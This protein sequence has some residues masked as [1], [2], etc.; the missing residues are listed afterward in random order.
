MHTNIPSHGYRHDPRRR[1]AI[2]CVALFV[3]PLFLPAAAPARSPA[4]P[5]EAV[6]FRGPSSNG[7]FPGELP[8]RR[9]RAAWTF[10]SDGPINASPIWAEGLVVVGSADGGLYG[11]DASTGRRKWRFATGGAVDGPAAYAEGR[12]FVESRDG[13]LYAVDAK[14]GRE[15]WRLALGPDLPHKWGW[16]YLLSGPVV[17]GSRLYVGSGAGEILAVDRG[18]GR[19]DWRFATSGRVRSSPVVADGVVYAGSFDGYLYALDAR[20]GTL[21]WKFATQGVSID[22][23]AAGF[24]RR[25]VQSSPAVAGDLVVVGCRDGHLY[26]VDRATGKERWNFDHQV[27]WVVGSAAI[28]GD[29]AVVG[30]SDARF[31]QAVELS[32]GKELWRARTDSNALSSP[33]VAGGIAV[34]GDDSGAVLAFEAATGREMWRFRTGDAVHSSPLV[35]DGRVYVGSDDGIL[36]ALERDPA[37]PA[38]PRA[39]RAVYFDPRV[40]YRS[41]EGDRELRD[42]LADASYRWVTRRD[43]AQFLE[44]RIADKE[45][46]VV[47]FATD[48]VPAALIEAKDGGAPLVRRYL[49]AGG[50]IVW[51]SPVPFLYT[52]DPATN[53]L[54]PVGPQDLGRARI[55]FGVETDNI[56]EGECRAEAT[57]LGRKWG[58][59]ARWWVGQGPVSAQP[60]IEVLARDEHGHAATWVKRFGGPEGTGLVVHWGRERRIP[61]PEVVRALAEHGLP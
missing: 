30:S 11:I 29:R 14:T 46:S 52:F 2:R 39:L 61:D 26:G 25:S 48:A 6:A 9:P 56:F 3:L 19:A 20:S 10:R 58:L 28:A 15:A 32:T 23:D 7:V 36:Y 42:F 41:F 1:L 27:S 40:P 38:P 34:L 18:T 12:F 50:K 17:S 45:P 44:A 59:S 5:A 24:D 60:G 57:E 4:A 31:V 37:S 16:D 53:Q 49:E 33:A 47:V 8:A 35:R 13:N 54:A 51:M 22:S 21:R 43:V 55:L